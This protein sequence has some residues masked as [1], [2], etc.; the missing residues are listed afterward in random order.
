MRKFLLTSLFTFLALTAWANPVQKSEFGT[1][2]TN[3]DQTTIPQREG[4]ARDKSTDIARTATKTRTAK[5]IRIEKALERKRLKR[6]VAEERK[7]R[8]AARKAEIK[9]KRCEYL[10]ERMNR[11]DEEARNAVGRKVDSTRI[12]S[13]RAT[14][15]FVQECKD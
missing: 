1:A 3:H 9:R 12:R 11:A 10:A 14:K 7:R 8:D 4:K 15:K 2:S 13:Q 6:E 5:E